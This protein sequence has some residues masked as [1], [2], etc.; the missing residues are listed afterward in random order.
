[1]IIKI[2]EHGFI[3]GR[4]HIKKDAL[5]KPV[6]VCDTGVF[7]LQTAAAGKKT[8]LTP[9]RLAKIEA[10]WLATR[11]HPE[12]RPPKRGGAADTDSQRGPKKHK[13]PKGGNGRPKG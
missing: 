11:P 9:E 4:Q 6:C 1:M 5:E 13:R 7:F 2:H 10:A 3:D 12:D 8:P